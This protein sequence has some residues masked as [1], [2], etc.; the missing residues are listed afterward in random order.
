MA[1]SS[2]SVSKGISNNLM[3]VSICFHLTDDVFKCI[4]YRITNIV[5]QHISHQPS[6]EEAR[7]RLKLTSRRR[8]FRRSKCSNSSTRWP[9]CS[10]RL[11]SLTSR[12]SMLMSC[13]PMSSKWLMTELSNRV[14]TDDSR[15][16]MTQMSQRILGASRPKRQEGDPSMKLIST[17][18]TPTSTK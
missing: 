3:K 6:V 16:F 5:F 15:Q 14:K 1:S 8:N 11:E 4:V 9:P 12:L 13:I 18:S 10:S 17:A 2:I 7:L